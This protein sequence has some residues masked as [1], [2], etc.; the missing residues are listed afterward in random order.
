VDITTELPQDAGLGLTLY[1]IVQE[2]LTNV[3]R[4]APDSASVKV[5]VA[6]DVSGTLHVTV[7]NRGGMA[8]L[9]P[10]WDGSGQGLVGMRQ[11]VAVYW[12]TL[13]AG[14]VAGGWRVHAT[15]PPEER[16]SE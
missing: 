1:R 7:D 14:P 5:S 3:L 16:D 12:G 4:Y 6:R 13:E 2:S 9:A 15:F 10:E 11:R 8:H